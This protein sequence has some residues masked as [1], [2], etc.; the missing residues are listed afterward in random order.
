MAEFA[1]IASVWFNS[2]D[3]H[4]SS[5][6]ITYRKPAPPEWESLVAQFDAIAASD[7]P[8]EEQAEEGLEIVAQSLD[9]KTRERN[10]HYGLGL[11]TRRF[12]EI[13]ADPEVGES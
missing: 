6:E 8:L 5:P 13:L 9:Q 10:R 11:V 12:S 4:M 1:I 7:K 3:K 2:S